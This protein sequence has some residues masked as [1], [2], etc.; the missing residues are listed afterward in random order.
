M[1]RNPENAHLFLNYMMRPDVIADCTNYIYY[2]NG[3]LASK[4]LISPD[5]L[6]RSGD[7]S[8]RRDPEAHV[9]ERRARRGGAA[10]HHAGVDPIEDRS[11]TGGMSAAVARTGEFSS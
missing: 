9:P 3:N 7:L 4:P 6:E 11:V 5:I 2:A 1:R 8:G 10:R